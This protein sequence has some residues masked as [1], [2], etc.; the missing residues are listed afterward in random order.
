MLVNVKIDVSG[1]KYITM[2]HTSLVLFNP[3]STAKAKLAI[4]AF[5]YCREFVK[6]LNSEELKLMDP[7]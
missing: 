6:T 4:L 3:N 7:F 1:Y 5:L 2:S